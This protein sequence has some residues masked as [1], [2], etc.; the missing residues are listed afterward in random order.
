[1]IRKL[2]YLLGA[3]CL[4]LL[5]IGQQA[6]AQTMTTIKGQVTDAATHLPIAGV[7]VQEKGGSQATVTD[8]KGEY[9]LKVHGTARLLLLFTYVGYATQE[10]NVGR[11]GIANIALQEGA[12]ALDQVVVTAYATEKKK[13]IT[14]AVSVVNMDQLT[15]QPS[16]LITDQLQGQASGV[17]V[18]QS[19]QPGVDPQIRIRGIN[20]FGNNTPL[21]VV[22]GVPT[23]TIADINANDI[24]SI[25]VLKDASASI[26][27]S[28][29]S[30]GVIILTTKRGKG[31]VTVH[32]D[33]YYGSQMPKSGNVWNLLDPTEQ[34][35]LE[36]QIMKNSGVANPSSPLYGNGATPVLP[37]YIAPEGAKE[38]DPSVSP[39][40]YY[41]NPDYT[42]LSDYSSFYRI[43]KANKT[44]TDW[45]HALSKNAPMTSHNLS[46][47]G[48]S[49][50]GSYLFSLSY[51]NQEGT[52]IETFLKRYSL[53]SN[54]EYN[55]SKNIR[56]GENLETS[57]SHS[58]GYT[59]IAGVTNSPISG[60]G[61][62][63]PIFYTMQTP[64][65]IP[66]YDIKGNYGGVF[67]TGYN[68]PN[69]VAIMQRTA[70]NKDVENRVFGNMYADVD[71]LRHFT[72]HTSF[73]GDNFSTSAHSFNYPTYE[74]SGNSS[75]N[76]FSQ[77]STDGF[78]W[79]WTNTL[80][81]HKQFGTD[82]S[83]KLLA[84]T[85]AYK[86]QTEFLGGTTFDFFSFDPN[87]T[88][89]SSGT[90]TQTNY[91]GR[92]LEALTSEFGRLDYA[93]KDKYLL[94]ATIRRD[95]S[96]KF[97]NDQ[98]GWFP[99][100][101]AGWRLSEEPFMR[102]APWINDLKIRASWGAMGNQLNVNAD[103]GYFTFVPDKTGS[104]YDIGGTNN[105]NQAGFEVGQIANPN[106]IWE[107]DYTTNIGF[108]ATLFH[109]KLDL[110]VDY[111]QKKIS[112]LLFAPPV[113]GTQGLGSVPFRNIAGMK[114][115]GL[116]LSANFHQDLTPKLRLD[117]GLTFTTYHNEITKVS[118]DVNYFYSADQR[119][120]G[121]DFIRNEVGHPVGAFYGYKI[122]GFWNSAAQIT[123]ADA[124][125][126]QAT[127]LA[128]ATYQ[129]DEAVGRFRYA[130]VNKDGQITAD[131]R[132]FLGNPNPKFNYG[133]NLKLNY[134]QFDLSLFFYG[135]Q[136]NQIWNVT[137]FWT[138]FGGFAEAKSKTA[139]YNSW[140]PQHMNAKAPIQESG[141]FASTNASPNSYY[142]ESG[143]YFKLK[144]IQIG[145][146]LSPG[147][148]KKMGISRLRV[149]VQGANLFTVT[150]YSGLDPEISGGGV[151]DFGVD[152]GI[153]PTVRQVLAGI[154]LNF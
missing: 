154:N 136:G 33:A 26:Y 4:M 85:E 34:A 86:L 1:M 118:D 149:Y 62:N 3:A 18:I 71:F 9:T 143:S 67:G 64:P 55:V 144:N 45:F 113:A 87:Y 43:T 103:N 140:T 31:N 110:S 135:V 74:N 130:D 14:G 139:L 124:Q 73:G 48:G 16:A 76:S 81:Y 22:D 117:L 13:D 25:Q 105:S 137:K 127:G 97:V 51:L 145:Y 84:G 17:T 52:I 63:S 54:A 126:A 88:T 2:N 109:S 29:A 12:T 56:I 78:S 37:D 120:F 134:E 46:V 90:G 100:V 133:F 96:S 114:N 70:N 38:G 92:N 75:T 80:T 141:S 15:K 151:T 40:L 49:D 152:E 132:T 112:G 11:S 99:A 20:T 108:D 42:D 5:L 39:S 8:E 32:Y 148:L 57:I 41:V 95:G 131:D 72:F 47:S 6:V 104:Y 91:S 10:S 66:V 44:G 138:D 123:A 65:I 129:A 79:T 146:S 53:R 30:N 101:S 61:P 36:W 83:L 106:A 89:L 153:Y 28:R 150:K 119:G 58:P 116:D 77:N 142:I 23:T 128:N 102:N 59:S 111:Y 122:A 24:A 125:A 68:G 82:H 94:S 93:Y 7:T 60:F 121:S 107:K 35:D 98:Y 21:Y 50:K 19:G 69:A 147:M 27:G 115:E